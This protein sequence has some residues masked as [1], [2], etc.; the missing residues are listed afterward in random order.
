[1]IKIHDI[2][3]CGQNDKQQA[4]G[5]RNAFTIVCSLGRACR[6]RIIHDYESA[7]VPDPSIVNR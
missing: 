2:T 7:V 4:A 3:H 6:S 1:M 5:N